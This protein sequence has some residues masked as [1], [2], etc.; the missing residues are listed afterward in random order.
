[1]KISKPLP[2]SSNLKRTK[3]NYIHHSNQGI[4]KRLLEKYKV[5]KEF[6]S[7]YVLNPLQAQAK[8]S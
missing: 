1:M 5:K 4:K 3:D 2:D 8:E 6:F 7:N